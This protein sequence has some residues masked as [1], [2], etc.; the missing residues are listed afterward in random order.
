MMNF[1]KTN[2]NQIRSKGLKETFDAQ[3]FEIDFYVIGATARVAA[4]GSAA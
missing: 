3:K 1:L 2:L 4:K